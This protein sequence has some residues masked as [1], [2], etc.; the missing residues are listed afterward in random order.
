MYSIIRL[1]DCRI[2]RRPATRHRLFFIT[3]LLAH[4]RAHPLPHKMPALHGWIN[5]MALFSHTVLSI[6]YNTKA[7]K[8][9]WKRSSSDSKAGWPLPEN[10][11]QQHFD[12]F[13]FCVWGTPCCNIRQHR[14]VPPIRIL[15]TQSSL[16]FLTRVYQL[17]GL[18]PPPFQLLSS[19]ITQKP[20]GFLG[21][22]P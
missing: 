5:S 2:M 17:S 20:V 13:L 21:K 12:L 8:Y 6:L 3:F 9:F 7:G 16:I 10:R 14:F 11:D 22:W 18:D 19:T 4:R 15:F 1:P